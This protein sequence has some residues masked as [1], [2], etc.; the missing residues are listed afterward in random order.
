MNA[1]E[2]LAAAEWGRLH[3]SSSP[4]RG[5]DNILYLL[6]YIIERCPDVKLHVYYGWLNW[7]SA[8]RSRG[9]DA[10]I[11]QI[12]EMKRQIQ[13]LGDHV[14]FHGRVNQAELAQEWKK[15]WLWLYPTN[16]TETFCCPPGTLVKTDGVERNIEDIEVGDSVLTHTGGY[17]QVQE[18]MRRDFRG[19][20]LEISAKYLLNPVRVTAEHPVLILSK[21]DA[22]CSRVETARCNKDKPVCIGPYQ[23]KHMGKLY[24]SEKVCQKLLAGYETKWVHAEEVRRGD[25]LCIP[26][27]NGDRKISE[28]RFSSF[29]SEEQSRRYHADG[30]ATGLPDVQFTPE[31]LELFGWYVAEGCSGSE[32]RPGRIVFSLNAAEQQES[33]FL[34]DQLRKLGLPASQRVKD[35]TRTLRTDCAL[36]SRFLCAQFGKG[37]RN[38]RIPTW[39]KQLSPADSKFFLR[40]LFQGDGNWSKNFARIEIGSQQLASDL[41][42]LLVKHDCLPSATSCEKPVP[43]RR[44]KEIH[45]GVVHRR[46]W[47]LS[48][49]L[50]HN[51]ELF[52]FFGYR[53]D[54]N[55]KRPFISDGDYVYTPVEDVVAKPYEGPVY[56]FEVEKDESYVANGV[57]V[58][59]CLTACEAQLSATPILC[60]DVAALKTTVGDAGTLVTGHP[61][62]REARVQYIDHIASLYHNTD[63]WLEA[64]EKSRQ[65]AV[66]GR[67]SWQDRWQ[68]YWAPLFEAAF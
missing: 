41:T 34:A 45:K 36:L 51:P 31:L 63:L 11:A 2:K 16:F 1:S 53:P 32:K 43:I 67:L 58:H 62:S 6:P 14:V 54:P 22:R 10:E 9:N 47:C 55:G 39:I 8:A 12:D 56:N 59:N 61:Y 21:R 18:V 27:I 38:K 20:I 30:V 49:S 26:K 19:S 68:D 24:V 5:L 50:S 37:A 52:E 25:L 33:D 3:Y 44:G 42:D 15:A 65:G 13:E 7:E 60:S 46:Y 40:G 64:V 57:V 17:R 4:D 48:V 29:I 28:F 35:N 66:T 23:Y